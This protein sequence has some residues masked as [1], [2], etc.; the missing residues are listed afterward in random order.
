MT[1]IVIFTTIIVNLGKL[2]P[3]FCLGRT[4][5]SL[6]LWKKSKYMNKDPDKKIGSVSLVLS[7][8][9]FNFA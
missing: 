9:D 1:N 2:G 7:V 4:N 8:L 3:V 6:N 5:L